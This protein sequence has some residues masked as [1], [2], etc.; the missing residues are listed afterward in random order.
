M[1]LRPAWIQT[2]L[3]ICIRAVWS[4]SMLFAISFS[5]CNRVCK[6]TAWLL[7]RL[8][9]C[10]GWS[11]SM[12]VANALCWFCR[13]AAH[14]FLRCKN[15]SRLGFLE[16]VKVLI[17]TMFKGT[18]WNTRL[19]NRESFT[20]LHIQNVIPFNTYYHFEGKLQN[21]YQF[22]NKSKGKNSCNHLTKITKGNKL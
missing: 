21:L 13:D 2:R 10:A 3:R 22:R 6:R 4:G 18:Y 17:H 14:I 11:G 9:G 7:I 8:R 19:F 16:H 1:G 12:L 20:R 5:T 15:L